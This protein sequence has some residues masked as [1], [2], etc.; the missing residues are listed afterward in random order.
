MSI[1][2]LKEIVAEF[3]ARMG[4]HG[5]HEAALAIWLAKQ[6]HSIWMINEAMR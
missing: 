2:Q 6:G 4:R 3:R 1:N 5:V